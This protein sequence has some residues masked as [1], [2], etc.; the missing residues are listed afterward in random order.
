M[1]IDSNHDGVSNVILSSQD[2]CVIGGV[3]GGVPFNAL[4]LLL[5]LLNETFLGPHFFFV[6][7]FTNRENASYTHSSC[8]L[9][10]L[11]LTFVFRMACLKWSCQSTRTNYKQFIFTLSIQNYQH[12]QKNLATYLTIFRMTL[13]LIMWLIQN[14]FLDYY[15][16]THLISNNSFF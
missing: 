4:L 6:V 1:S 12:Q 8:M 5:F 16:H 13:L 2:I 3:E 15:Q 14:L 11:S 7:A 9:L 10:T